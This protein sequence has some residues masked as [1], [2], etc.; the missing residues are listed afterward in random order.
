[1]PAS[2]TKIRRPVEQLN[3][4][5]FPVFDLVFP[6]AMLAS[7]V[8]IAALRLCTGSRSTRTLSACFRSSRGF[9]SSQA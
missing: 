4:R 2:A 3:V 8:L 1:M 5:F 6:S 7:V 9:S